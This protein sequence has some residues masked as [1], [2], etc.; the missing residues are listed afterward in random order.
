[1]LSPNFYAFPAGRNLAPSKEAKKDEKEKK[2]RLPNYL[3]LKTGS[4]R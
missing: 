3:K 1:M 4:A 2:E